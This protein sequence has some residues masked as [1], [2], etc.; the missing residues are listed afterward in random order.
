MCPWLGPVQIVGRV[1]EGSRFTQM[2]LS[3]NILM[4]V[5]CRNLC[6]L[7]ECGEPL[8]H[9]HGPVQQHPNGCDLYECVRAIFTS[10]NFWA[11]WR[12]AALCSAPE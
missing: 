5:T 4:A 7:Q 9:L 3:S 10:K 1:L 12:R 11:E 6:C 2:A 8:A